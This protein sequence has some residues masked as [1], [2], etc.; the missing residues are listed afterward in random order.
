MRELLPQVVYKYTSVKWGTVA[1]ESSRIR[2]TQPGALNDPFE[3][4]PCM[5]QWKAAQLEKSK[6]SIE[7]FANC[8]DYPGDIGKPAEFLQSVVQ[9]LADDLVRANMNRLFAFL[10]LSKLRDNI[11]MWSH[12][13]EN[14]TG[15]VVG[16]D[17][18]NE[19]FAPGK[20]SVG[21]LQSV[22]YSRDRYLVPATGF[23]KLS[24]E[25]AIAAE[26]GFFFTKS[27]D[28]EY[29]VEMRLLANPARA[30]NRIEGDDGVPIYLYNFPPAAVREI[31][32]GYR[33]QTEAKD[34]IVALQSLLYPAANIVQAYVDSDECDS[35]PLSDSGGDRIMVPEG[36]PRDERIGRGRVAA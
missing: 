24:S 22:N 14:H 25:Q 28:W 31:V 18:T 5:T 34:K 11:L 23:A 2:F 20:F 21:G 36:G 8:P 32:F 16:F 29:E 13:A 33:M 17:T 10:S 1:L 35:P 7:S 19:M 6:H 12:Y 4:L 27:L 26:E 15:L 3:A 30:D 9:C